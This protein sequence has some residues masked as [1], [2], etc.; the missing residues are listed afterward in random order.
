MIAGEHIQQ[1]G[2]SL[3]ESLIALVVLSIGL[4]G[5]AA[6]QLKAMQSANAGYQRSMASVAA[7]DAQERLWAEFASLQPD[8]TCVNI[9]AGQVQQQW[10]AHWLHNVVHTPLR[11]ASPSLTTIEV[12]QASHGC[13]VSVN[14]ALSDEEND[15]FEYT[16]SL[17][18]IGRLP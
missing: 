8:Q 13:H 5:V 14:V 17:P 2:F 9:D 10:K 12:N 7:V 1:R 15:Q 11:G 4:V 3:I 16:F 18:L 6:M